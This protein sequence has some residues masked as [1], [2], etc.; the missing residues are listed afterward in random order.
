MRAPRVDPSRFVR[1]RGAREHNLKDVDVDIPRDALVVFTGVSGSGKSSLAFGTLYAEAQRRYFESVAPY[2]RRLID[3][4]GVPDVDAIDGLPPA[5]ALQ[6]Q[7][8]TPSARSSVGSVTTL[9]SLLRM[10]YSRAGS[11]PPRPADALR[12]G[13]LAQHAAGC[14]PELPRPRPRLRSDRASM[15]PDPSL[16]IRERAIA[17]W[18]PAWHGQNLRDI[19]VTLGHDVDTPWRELPKKTRDW[20]LYTD[21]QPTVPVYPGFTPAETRSAL[22][23]K[24]EPAYMGT[25]TGVRKYVLHTFATTQSPLMKKRVARFMVGSVCPVCNGKR[26]KREA[27]SVTFAGLDIGALA[28]LP[29]SRVADVLRPAAENRFDVDRCRPRHARQPRNRRFSARPRAPTRRAASPPAVPRTPARP[30]SGARPTFQKKSASPPNA[31]RPMSSPASARSSRSASATSRSSAARRRC[32]PASYS[33]CA[34]RRRSARTCSASSTCS[35]SRPPA[36]T[37]RTAP[38]CYDALDALKDAGNSI[39]VV[40]HDLDDDAARRLDRRRRPGR[41]RVRRPRPLQRRA[42]WAG[43]SR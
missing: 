6:Q 8:G 21:E 17:A 12:R 27:L 28:Q 23:R 31:S 11:Y 33:G 35:T 2:A 32:R 25:F 22:R 1:V 19:L 40:E 9:S 7:R 41:R 3:Q 36:C 13:L 4:I 20:I 5:V 43:A 37:R 42:G 38:P 30:T 15:V 26:L 29:L 18:P 39:F 14:V 10:L 24:T 34:W 16:T